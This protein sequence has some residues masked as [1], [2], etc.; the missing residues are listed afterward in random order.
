MND[1]IWSVEDIAAYLRISPQTARRSVI[2]RPGFP[3]GFRPTGHA[4]GERRWF[5]EDVREWA[6]QVA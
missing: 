4:R 1:E 2:T 3:K 6:R 5:S